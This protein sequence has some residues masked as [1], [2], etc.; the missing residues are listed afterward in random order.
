MSQL[1]NAKICV[2]FLNEDLSTFQQSKAVND[3]KVV[4]FYRYLN[5]SQMPCF[6]GLGRG[7]NMSAWLLGMLQFSYNI[8]KRSII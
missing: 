3:A 7:N 8:Q 6:I 2:N 4:R 5:S 1:I